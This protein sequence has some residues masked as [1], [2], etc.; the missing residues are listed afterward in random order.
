MLRLHGEF[1]VAYSI[2]QDG[3]PRP[4]PAYPVQTSLPN[5]WGQE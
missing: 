2:E 3:F 5:G 4:G 1:G